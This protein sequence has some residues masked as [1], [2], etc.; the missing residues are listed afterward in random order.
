MISLCDQIKKGSWYLHLCTN[1]S[2][3]VPITWE[4][5]RYRLKDTG[6]GQRSSPRLLFPVEVVSECACVHL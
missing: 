1:L 5:K 6:N 4:W 2:A 3:N